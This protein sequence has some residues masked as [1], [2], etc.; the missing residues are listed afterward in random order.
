M[1]A[2]IAIACTSTCQVH[3]LI[4]RITKCPESSKVHG[5]EEVKKSPLSVSVNALI[6]VEYQTV[7]E[8]VN[9]SRSGPVFMESAVDFCL[10]ATPE[11]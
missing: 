5:K 1:H 2:F 7:N 3:K 9:L 11:I 4:N 6:S 8:C 10:M